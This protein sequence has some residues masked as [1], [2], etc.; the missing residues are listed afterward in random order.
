M[1]FNQY[2]E[3]V[4]LDP[5]KDRKILTV[6]AES[7]TKRCQVMLP[8]ELIAGKTILDLG[9]ALGAMG[10]WSLEHGASLYHGVE[11]QKGYRD[12]SR[13]LLIE[14]PAVNIFNNMDEVE[15]QYDIIIAAGII[16]G[17][18]YLTEL[19]K[20]I[21]S[22]SLTYV[23]IESHLIEA[24]DHPLIVLQEGN[25][26]N[27]SGLDKTFRGM[28]M[29]PNKPALNM[30]MKINGFNL[31]KELYPEPIINSHDAYN[32]K[33]GFDRFISRYVRTEERI[34]TLEEVINV[35]I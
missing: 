20:N 10:K 29:I 4:N 7:L 16:H 26:V 31:D 12:K 9:S 17:V 32:S 11:V 1:W 6:T 30:L 13:E 27:H 2:P 24:G 33:A 8:Q 19:L 18:F 5:R 3:F 14:Y 21:C 35:A 23:I 34:K 28:Q 15:N 25:M 22:K